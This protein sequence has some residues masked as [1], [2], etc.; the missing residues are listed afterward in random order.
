MILTVTRAIG[1]SVVEGVNFLAE[2]GGGLNSLRKLWLWAGG[3]ASPGYV[4]TEG[5]R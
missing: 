4:L 5:C 2:R 1:L 3:F